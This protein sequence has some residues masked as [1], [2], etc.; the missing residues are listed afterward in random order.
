MMPLPV[1]EVYLIIF[2]GTTCAAVCIS[3]LVLIMHHKDSTCKR[4][5]HWLRK[6]SFGILG[7]L[8]CIENTPESSRGSNNEVSPARTVTNKN[9]NDEVTI[10]D[11]GSDK[12]LPNTEVVCLMGQ[13]LSE[14]R[15]LSQQM[16]KTNEANKAEWKSIANIIDKFSFWV[17][18]IISVVASVVILGIVPLGQSK[19]FNDLTN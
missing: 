17:F 11:V 16:D 2:M 7:G 13:I 15:Q 3:V 18:L 5:P 6:I 9:K 8:L 19:S 10:Q 12:E 1:S 4:A 14:V